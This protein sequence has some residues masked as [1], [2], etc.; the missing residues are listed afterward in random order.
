MNNRHLQRTKG[1]GLFVLCLF[2]CQPV[3]RKLTPAFYHW[4]T[5]LALS[6]EETDFLDQL[7][8]GRLYVKFL[9]IAKADGEISP[10]ALLEVI[11]TAGLQGRTVIPCVFIANS[12]FQDIDSE[13]TE[14]LAQKTATALNSAGRQF[15]PAVFPE[16]QFDCDWTASTRDAFFVYLKKMRA[17]LPAGIR[18]SATIRLHQYKFPQQ[19]GVPPADRGMLMLYNTGDIDDPE[20][21]NSI[22]KPADA[23]IYL[24]GAPPRYPLPLDVALP[25]FSW[26]LVYRDGELWKIIPDAGANRDTVF[27]VERS[28]FLGGHYLRP[29]DLVRVETVDSALLQQ[30]AVQAAGLPLAPDAAVAFFHLD[31]SA[32]RRFP[33]RVLKKAW[34]TI[35]FNR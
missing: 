15:T 4:Q 6:P 1:I 29:G 10:Y 19:T 32:V 31:S 27:Y 33:V 20:E 12:V 5:Q 35:Q 2:A 11:D 14:W 18:I 16:V 24:Q 9:D 23:D 3:P 17:Q 7:G 34:E 26:S 8:C 28:T 30:A 21:S 22:F 13:K 25:V